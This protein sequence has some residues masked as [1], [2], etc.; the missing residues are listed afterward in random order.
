[1]K[2]GGKG[3]RVLLVEDNADDEFLALRLLRKH[4]YDN[5]MVAR[6]GAEAIALLLGEKRFSPRFVLLDLK[7]PKM[8]GFEVIK[9]MRADE[10]T[11]SIPV[12]VVS[13]SRDEQDREICEGL[14]VH[15]YL[16][17]PL[18]SDEFLACVAKIPV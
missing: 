16:T 7:L 4:G 2:R 14:G 8:G 9:A 15:A 10:R 3:E 6:D 13:S 17:K 18:K 12:I 1:M 5:V 11:R